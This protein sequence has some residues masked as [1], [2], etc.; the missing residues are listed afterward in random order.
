MQKRRLAELLPFAIKF[1]SLP[2]GKR[3]LTF[4][5]R[6]DPTER[7]SRPFIPLGHR[8]KVLFTTIKEVELDLLQK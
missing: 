4:D 2:R 8:L 1:P 7:R 5:M 3:G 6:M